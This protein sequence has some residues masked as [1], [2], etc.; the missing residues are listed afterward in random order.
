MELRPNRAVHQGKARLGLARTL[1]R[2]ATAVGNEE[3]L[4]DAEA[5]GRA[6]REGGCVNPR[7][8]EKTEGDTNQNR[9]LCGAG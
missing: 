7:L 4:D 1:G 5:P 8:L 9:T 6:E 2:K 3:D